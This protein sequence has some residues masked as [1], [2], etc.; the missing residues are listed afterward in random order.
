MTIQVKTPLITA[1]HLGRK[2]IVYV[3]KSSHIREE[4]GRR[5]LHLDQFQLAR[6]YGWTEHLIEVI[7][8]DVGKPGSS[9]EH[10]TGW[11]C[12]LDQI[13]AGGVAAIFAAS[14]S[15]LSRQ[16]IEYEQLRMLASE[17]GTLLC[18]GNRVIDPSSSND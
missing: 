15:R 1:E 14:V 18:I 9:V 10:R 13:I 4:T 7:D 3:R 17:H 11:R 6:Q 8:E 16:V 12:M 2:A 5:A